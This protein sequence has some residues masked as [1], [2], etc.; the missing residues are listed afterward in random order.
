MVGMVEQAISDYAAAGTDAASKLVA[1]TH[2]PTYSI[3][4]T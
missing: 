4:S 3:E 2:D 1:A